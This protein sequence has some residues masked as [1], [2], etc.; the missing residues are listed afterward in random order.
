MIWESHD[1]YKSHPALGQPLGEQARLLYQMES[2]LE[3]SE[4]AA[5]E[6]E[7]AARQAAAQR[8]SFE[9]M[10]LRARPSLLSDDITKRLSCFRDGLRISLEIDEPLTGLHR[11][12]KRSFLIPVVALRRR[13]ERE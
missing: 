9:R 3:H 4:A 12:E 7:L 1:S 10:R 11:P 5:T 6:D 8:L 2:Q 13:P